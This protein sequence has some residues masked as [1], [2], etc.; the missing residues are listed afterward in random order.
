M[1]ISTNFDGD[2]RKAFQEGQE[3][4]LI[5][6]IVVNFLI[7]RGLKYPFVM[8]GMVLLPQQMKI[9]GNLLEVLGVERTIRLQGWK[10]ALECCSRLTLSFF[11]KSLEDHRFVAQ[12]SLFKKG[13]SQPFYRVDL[14]SESAKFN[15]PQ[16]YDF[17]LD[18]SLQYITH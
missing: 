14:L 5:L 8:R 15:D 6:H 9:T 4:L 17:Y 16:P 7:Y 3:A 10:K 1:K 13:Q 18:G 2:S 11:C 12:V